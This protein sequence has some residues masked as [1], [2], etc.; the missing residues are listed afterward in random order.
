MTDGKWDNLIFMIEE[1][2]GILARHKGPVEISKDTKGESIM[3][4]IESIE[5]ETPNGKMKIERFGRP[6]VIDKK[7]LSTKR[8][9]GRVAVDYVYSKEEKSYGVKLYRLDENSHWQEVDLAA[10]A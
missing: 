9:G 8:I 3:G 1:K 10:I 7:V 5:F 6:K 2:F 4:D